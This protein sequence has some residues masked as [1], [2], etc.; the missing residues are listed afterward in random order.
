MRLF[1]PRRIPNCTT[2]SKTVSTRSSLFGRSMLPSLLLLALCTSR[3]VGKETMLQRIRLPAFS[4][5]SKNLSRQRST[6]A[7][8]TTR[9]FL[10]DA[11]KSPKDE[12][13]SAISKSRAPFKMPRN[14]P[15]DSFSTTSEKSWSTLGLWPPVVDSLTQELKL[16]SP[17]PVQVIAI[18]ALLKYPPQ[19]VCFLAATGSGKTLSYALPLLQTLKQND[20]LERPSKRP[21]LLILAPT[22]ELTLQITQVVKRL[23]HA[24]KFSTTCLTGGSKTYG[25]Q[26]KDLDRSLDVVVATPA[27]LLQHWKDQ[28]VFLGNVQHIVLDEMDTMLEQGFATELKALLYP[29]LYRKKPTDVL[30]DPVTDVHEGTPQLVLTSATMTQA[31]LKM[32]GSQTDVEGVTAKK[33]YQKK[34]ESKQPA[35]LVLPKMLVLKAPGLHKTIPRLQQVF[36]DVGG[37]DKLDLLVDLMRSNQQFKMI[38]VFCNTAAACRAVQFALE[39]ADLQT[40]AY[41]GELN[42]AV[43]TQNLKDYRAGARSTLVCTDLAARGLDIPD[44]D[45]VVLFDFPLNA[46]DYLHRTGRTARQGRPGRVSALVTKRDQVLANAIERAVQRGEPVDGLSSRKS[47]YLP[48]SQKVN[49]KNQRGGKLVGERGSATD[50]TAR[51]ARRDRPTKRDQ[52]SANANPRTDQRD[53]RR[54]PIDTTRKKSVAP[55]KKKVKRR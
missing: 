34:E 14:S 54:G 32:V 22:R 43:R 55:K 23:S 2:Y 25:K 6:A 30:V 39:Q 42:S 10:S 20:E 13:A 7:S 48:S 35:L 16:E 50:G 31:I 49:T 28:N 45:H 47:D 46:A 15:D 33:L 52:A 4:F 37:A 41:H 9:L 21:R 44:V 53:K 24:L 26:A 27:R 19:H 38:M 1:F 29:V 17:T 12:D 5:A 36:V 40:L 18:P 11:P 8:T 3:A 51:T